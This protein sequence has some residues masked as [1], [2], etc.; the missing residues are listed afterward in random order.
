MF[1]T[2]SELGKLTQQ[3]L[4]TDEELALFQ[5][6]GHSYDLDIENLWDRIENV[7]IEIS[8]Q[9][10]I[11]PM[12]T[13]EIIE[14]LQAMNKAEINESYIKNDSN[15]SLWFSTGRIPFEVKARDKRFS[16]ETSD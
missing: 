9:E 2:D 13:I 1:H 11:L 12:T 3:F 10:N 14:Y 8:S 5:I 7:L 4:A 15:I 6:A 16:K